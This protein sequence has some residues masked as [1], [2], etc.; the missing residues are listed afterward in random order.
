ML[1][2]SL[3]TRYRLRIV[4]GEWHIL[5]NRFVDEHAMGHVL[6]SWEWGKLKEASGWHVLRLALWD[7]EEQKI[8]AGAQVLQRTAPGV[9]L[10]AGHLAYVPKG[11]VLDWSQEALVGE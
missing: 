11:P 10:R 7:G 4:P 9:P 1:M 3:S 8:V 2:A 6:Q 5:W